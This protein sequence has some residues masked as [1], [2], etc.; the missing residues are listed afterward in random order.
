MSGVAGRGAFRA[1][2]V[3]HIDGIERA[4]EA[5][6]GSPDTYP[7]YDLLRLR[8]SEGASD[9]LRLVFAVAGFAP[10]QLEIA[11]AGDQ[12]LI[13]GEGS[14]D[15]SPSRF[16]HR[17][18]AARR[19]RRAFRLAPG[20]DVVDVELDLGLLSVALAIRTAERT[21]RTVAIGARSQ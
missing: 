19:F 15:G 17:G 14:G 1:T 7:P 11:V 2:V 8:G 18:I 21:S 20:L 4:S 10:D 16:L 13:S 5:A 12:L 6:A 9:G 3:L